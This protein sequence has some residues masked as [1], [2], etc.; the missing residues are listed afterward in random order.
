METIVKIVVSA[1]GCYVFGVIA[2]VISVICGMPVEGGEFFAFAFVIA[3]KMIIFAAK[4]W[5]EVTTFLFDQM[6]LL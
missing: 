1:I 2:T 3:V 5:L 4:I 6:S